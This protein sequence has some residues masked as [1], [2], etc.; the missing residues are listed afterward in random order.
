MDGLIW[1]KTF[2][3]D[4]EFKV[5]DVCQTKFENYSAFSFSY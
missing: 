1:I 5:R 4:F 3:K 2:K